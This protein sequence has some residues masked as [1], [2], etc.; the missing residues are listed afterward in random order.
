LKAGA[1]LS[2]AGLAFQALDRDSRSPRSLNEGWQ[3]GAA[4]Q[5][6]ATRWPRRRNC[7]PAI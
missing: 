1:K 5:D 7:P 2:R 4:C 6:V 3:C